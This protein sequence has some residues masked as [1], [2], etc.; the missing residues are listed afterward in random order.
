MDLLDSDKSSLTARGR[1]FNIFL[2]PRDFN[3]TA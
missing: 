1:E 2:Y 3:N